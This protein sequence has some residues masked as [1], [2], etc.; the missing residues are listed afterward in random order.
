[1]Y[2]TSFLLRLAKVISVMAIGIMAAVIAFGNI[3]DYSKII[4]LWSMY[5]KWIQLLMT[6]A[7]ITGV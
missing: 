6:A 7:F 5:S 3:T 4:N 1:M 2:S